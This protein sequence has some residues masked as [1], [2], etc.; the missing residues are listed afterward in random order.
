MFSQLY[1]SSTVIEILSKVINKLYNVLPSTIA[2]KKKTI[3][4]QYFVQ[5]MH[6]Y[7]LTCTEPI[8]WAIPWAR[9][10]LTVYFAR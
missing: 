4:E 8:K 6:Q 1:L 9:D 7:W 10:G 5:P 3:T 2:I